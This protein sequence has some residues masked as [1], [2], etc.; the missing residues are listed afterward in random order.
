M[1]TV[2]RWC[3]DDWKRHRF[4][5]FNATGPIRT[6]DECARILNITKSM[7]EHAELTAFIK[8]RAALT[9]FK[10]DQYQ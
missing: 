7:A 9:P 5:K 8:I 6:F 3:S 10:K 1:K 4:G 2:A